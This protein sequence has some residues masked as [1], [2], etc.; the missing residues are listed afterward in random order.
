M[1]N[2]KAVSSLASAMGCSSTAS[3]RRN[4]AFRAGRPV[5]AFDVEVL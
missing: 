5:D 2:E 3:A 4:G 1:D